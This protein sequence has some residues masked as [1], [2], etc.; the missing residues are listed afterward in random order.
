MARLFGRDYTRQQLLDRVGDISQIAGIREMRLAGGRQDGVE[1]LEFRT[2]SGLCF[3]AVPGRSLDIT[4][5]EHKGRPLAWRSPAGETAGAFYEPEGEGWIR[6]LAGGLLATCGLTQVGAPCEDNGESLGLH[7]RVSH[8]PATN[9]WSDS[10]WDGDEFRMWASGKVRDYCFKG[11]NLLLSRKISAVLGQ[12][13]LWVDDT[14]TNEGPNSTPHMILYHI[15]AGFPIVDAGSELIT[16]GRSVQPADAD[17]EV[18]KE[19][20]YL[21]EPPTPGW[22]DRCYYHEMDADQ[23]GWACAAVINRDCDGGSLGIYVKYRPSELPMFTQWKRNAVR[24]YVVGME[25]ANC[26]IQGRSAERANGTLQFLEPGESR[27]Y[28]LELG[29]LSCADHVEQFEK[30]IKSMRMARG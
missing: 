19:H 24:E 9:V 28:H 6:S 16:T 1:A 8:T 7:G 11:E 25:P 10:A 13:K 4:T 20:Y 14:V 30:R 17:A 27:R 23:D 5:A 3:L 18:D 29:V 12:S 21:C 22:V 2:G 15:N 26:G